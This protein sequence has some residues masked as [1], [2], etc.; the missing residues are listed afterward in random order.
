MNEE[1]TEIVLQ[2]FIA[3][4]S[5][6]Q[7]ISMGMFIKFGT[8]FIMINSRSGCEGKLMLLISTVF[9]KFRQENVTIYACLMF[10]I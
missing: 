10:V 5:S 4:C 7:S 1:Y 2:H 6:G 3:A 8:C 9:A